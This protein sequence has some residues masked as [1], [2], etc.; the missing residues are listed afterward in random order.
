MFDFFD[1]NVRWPAFEGVGQFLH[2]HLNDTIV[3]SDISVIASRGASLGVNAFSNAGQILYI[4]GVTAVIGLLAYWTIRM[5]AYN[6]RGG[7]RGG[8]N[9]GVIEGISVGTTSTVQLIRAGEKYLVIGVTKEK[10]TLL[11]E[12]DESEVNVPEALNMPIPF[13]KVIGRF[14]K[15]EQGSNE[16]S[17][18]C[19]KEHEA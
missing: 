2:I 12:L 19:D 17:D 8:K 3:R 1:I 15:G 4:I 9:L 18:E 16:G 13:E 14:I 7:G 6:K 5:M 10:V 11:V